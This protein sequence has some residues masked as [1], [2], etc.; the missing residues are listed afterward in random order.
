M[1]AQFW[2]KM[3]DE[4]DRAS[5][6]SRDVHWSSRSKKLLAQ[7]HVVVERWRPFMAEIAPLFADFQKLAAVGR[8]QPEIPAA[9]DPERK[10]TEF[11]PANGAA[12]QRECR[13][14]QWVVR[15]GLLS[16]PFVLIDVG[17]QDGEDQRWRPLGD[18]LVVHGFDPIAEVVQKLPR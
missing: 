14:H 3:E 18:H 1:A 6:P 2:A 10:V 7:I 15:A 11:T 5:D 13:V 17:V 12:A 9:P 16:E 8:C 4:L